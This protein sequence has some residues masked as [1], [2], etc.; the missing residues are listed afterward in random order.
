MPSV[1]KPCPHCG[2]DPA[3]EACEPWQRTWGPRPWH[4]GCYKGGEHEHYIGVNGD[5][6]SEAIAKWDR[7][8]A[9]VHVPLGPLRQEGRDVRR[10]CAREDE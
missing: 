8:V 3:I 4:V 9:T 1:L 6:R 5:T 10:H 7:K 2:A